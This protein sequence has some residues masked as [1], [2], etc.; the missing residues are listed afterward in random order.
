MAEKKLTLSNLLFH[1]ELEFINAVH[2]KL[3][4]SVSAAQGGSKETQ[5]GIA[6]LKTLQV[7]LFL[8]KII[9]PPFFN[10]FFLSSVKNG[11]YPNTDAQI[12]AEIA[13]RAAK[14]KKRQIGPTMPPSAAAA[15]ATDGGGGGGKV[16][17]TGA[18]A[19][20]GAAAQQQWTPE[21]VNAYWT[22]YY[23]A[24]SKAQEGEP[25]SLKQQNEVT[26]TQT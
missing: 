19:T 14:K 22:Q 26:I 20:A 25:S 1:S 9:P 12:E 6:Q 10:F 13:K 4:G 3:D 24:A 5:Q 21:Q 23:A 16:A 17:K 15:A 2:S 8:L 11:Q 18:A 7:R